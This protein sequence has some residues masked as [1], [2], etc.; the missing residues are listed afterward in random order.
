MM[1]DFEEIGT[2]AGPARLK[3]TRR[4]TLAISV[5]PDGTLELI[6]PEVSSVEAIVAKVEKRKKWISTQRRTFSAMNAVKPLPRYCN[7]ATHRYLGKQYR[8]KISQSDGVRVA[9]RGGYIHVEL[10]EISDEAVKKALSSW[11][12]RLASD[13][14]SKRIQKWAEWCRQ[15]KLP[16]PQ[17]RLRSMGKRWG[18][19]LPDGRIY[20]NPELIHAPSACIDYVITHEICHLKHPDHGRGFWN[21]LKQLMPDWQTQKARLERAEG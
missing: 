7:G 4:K 9:L 16:E 6:A 11:F 1:S 15:R 10:I 8:L 5:L 21:L 12:R 2:P 3:R 19:A 20:L 17:V 14:F 18:S 13:Q